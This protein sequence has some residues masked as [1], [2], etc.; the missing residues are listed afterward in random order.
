MT[1]NDICAVI[2]PGVYGLAWNFPE[3]SVNYEFPPYTIW[4]CVKITEKNLAS[5]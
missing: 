4:D 1:T 2:C 5:S 3:Q